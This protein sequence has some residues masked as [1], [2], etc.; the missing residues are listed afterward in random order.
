M[1]A[2]GGSVLRRVGSGSLLL[3]LGGGAA[4]LWVVVPFLRQRAEGC[5]AAPFSRVMQSGLKTRR[6]RTPPAADA[7][8]IQRE[9]FNP[10]AKG[11]YASDMERY[12]RRNG[13]RVFAFR[14]SLDDLSRHLAKGR[15]LIVCLRDSGK[16]G[17]L[18]YVVVVGFESQDG[19]ILV[20]DPAQR[21]LLK[22]DLGDFEKRWRPMHNW[23]LLAVPGPSH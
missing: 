17:P 7:S 5:G 8:R 18:H 9:L 23:T 13:F 3:G 20:N 12:F 11:I 16:S 1:G 19:V 2:G 21:K 14:G 4:G 22:M 6:E 15:P 10:H